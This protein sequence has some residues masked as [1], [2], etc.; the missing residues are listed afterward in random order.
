VIVMEQALRM[1]F[2]EFKRKYGTHAARDVLEKHGGSTYLDSVPPENRVA[3]LKDLGFKPEPEAT[4]A[5]MGGR[6][7]ETQSLDDLYAAAMARF[8]N[9]PR[10]SRR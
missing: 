9:P 3:L 4:H 6:Q 2:R 1:A 5:N 8:N 7:R 10:R